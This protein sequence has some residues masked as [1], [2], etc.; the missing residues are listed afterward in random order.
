[1]SLKKAQAIANVL[2]RD[3]G[4]SLASYQNTDLEFLKTKLEEF[5]KLDVDTE[6]LEESD[7]ALDTE[8]DE[9]DLND[10]EAYFDNED[11]QFN[12]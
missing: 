8:W 5:L 2:D 10:D 9:A 1:M 12:V 11:E 4:F 7:D 3:L 6:E